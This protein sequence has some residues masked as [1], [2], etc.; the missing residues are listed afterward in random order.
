MSLGRRLTEGSRERGIAAVA[1][2]VAFPLA[3]SAGR[4]GRAVLDALLPPRCL[5]CLARVELAGRLCPACWRGVDFIA[6]PLCAVCGFPFAHD[7]G[8]AA[9]CGAC[10]AVAPPFA[11]AR[12]VFRYGGAGR[13]LVLAFKHGD[14]TDAAPALAAWLARAGP[15][16]VAAADAI[17]PVP[18][19]RRR[20]FARRYNQAALLAGALGR[21]AGRPVIADLL[22]RT[23][24]TPSQ[25]GLS[26]RARFLNVR[27]AFAVRP[28]HRIAGARV[29]LIDDVMTTGATAAAC[30]RA[31]TRAGA[32]RVDVLTLARVVPEG[33]E[34]Y[35][36]PDDTHP[37]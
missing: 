28:R 26:R 12:S 8:E 25:G 31:L 18:L 32:R 2:R 30:A 6:P 3:G 19:H 21:L 37:R 20:L 7:E 16:M 24:P 13:A 34:S 29:L 33:G 1:E 11:R 4:L 5:A 36:M 22:A 17:A 9:L 23:R 14:R 10:A 35:M 27:G 15:E